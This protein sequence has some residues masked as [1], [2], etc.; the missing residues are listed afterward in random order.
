MSPAGR[1]VRRGRATERELKELRELREGTGGGSAADPTPPQAPPPCEAPRAPRVGR[2]SHGAR[3]TTLRRRRAILACA[4][5]AVVIGAGVAAAV[6][7]SGSGGPARAHYEPAGGAAIAT[8]ITSPAPPR[9]ALPKT[10]SPAF[11]PAPAATQLAA[12]M[13]L[14][15]QVAQL[16][17]VGVD[18]NTSAAATGLGSIPWGGVV[19]TSAN[20]ASNSQVQALTSQIT[21]IAGNAGGVTP[22][23]AAEQS[24]EPE[25]AFPDLPPEG[26]AQIG[27]TGK[28]SLAR[29][30][31]IA[32]GKA[33]RTLGIEM[34]IAPLADVDTLDGALSG[35]L[36]SSN[37]AAVARFS[38]AAVT[39][40]QQ[41]GVIAAAAHFPGEGGASADPDEMTATV[42]GSLTQLEDRDLLPFAAITPHVPVIVMSNAEYTAFDG[43]TPASLLP[44]AVALLRGR[45]GFTGVIMSDDLDA[46]LDATGQTPGQVAV[47]ALRAGDDLLYISGPPSEHAT[48]Y[49]AVLTRAEHSA[50]ARA[51]VHQALL[52]DLT[53][54]A[55][56]GLLSP[57]G[58]GVAGGSTTGTT[59][60]P[61]ATTG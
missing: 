45:Y 5:A 52:R 41:S 54:K 19:L 51:L 23:L 56:A 17:M 8:V 4:L 39:G 10:R 27:A 34:T 31:A 14:P 40:Y 7:S 20:F 55:H 59:T 2:A 6:A 33:L 57:S 26:E 43:V 16:F 35:R 21:D 37:P 36:F 46:T 28:P 3:R 61:T 30:Q 11:T 47:R 60:A 38:L 42:G 53:L 49:T 1:R 13:S 12:N 58:S 29:T 22:L 50:P 25:T 9:S 48:A 44:A 32:A 18:G 24:G 15:E